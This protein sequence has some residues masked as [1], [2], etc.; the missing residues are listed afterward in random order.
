[1][2]TTT[3]TAV[4]T[5]CT[6]VSISRLS[7]GSNR[8][9]FRIACNERRFDRGSDG[10]IDGNSFY[11]SVTCFRQLA[12]NVH[13]SFVCGD[14]IMVRGRIYT[15]EYDKDGRRNFITE[16]IADAV[17][18]DLTRCTSKI[19]R[20]VRPAPAVVDDTRAPDPDADRDDVGTDDSASWTDADEVLRS[21][22]GSEAVP[23]AGH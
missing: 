9:W 16:I 20:M 10:W 13:S 22:I 3:M 7:D 14:P 11:V 21:D 17:G 6:P 18:P 19:I 23:A 2:S 15:R 5:L 1:M 4:G 8:I 12:E